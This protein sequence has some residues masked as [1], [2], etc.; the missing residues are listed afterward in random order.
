MSSEP[1]WMVAGKPGQILSLMPSLMQAVGVVPKRHE[2]GGQKKY[3]FRSIDDVLVRL[4]PALINAGITTSYE[5]LH[6]RRDRAGR[7]HTAEVTLRMLYVAPD[8]SYVATVAAGEA[9]DDSDKATN[10]ALTCAVK[11]AHLH[12]FQVPTGTR[13]D[14]EHADGR[15]R[16]SAK[17]KAVITQLEMATDPQEV[18]AI[19]D[20]P[21]Y[22]GVSKN[23][24]EDLRQ[25][26]ASR[27]RQLTARRAP[28]GPDD[29]PA[30]DFSLKETRP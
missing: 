22:A 2:A 30:H 14:I 10:K 23:E 1:T 6:L 15:R 9:V 20:A 21:A 19:M 24:R 11:N 26:A 16:W 29:W 18:S 12:T 3:K 4:Q 8:G 5:V 13:R 7:W 17:A 28:G 27:W 25:V